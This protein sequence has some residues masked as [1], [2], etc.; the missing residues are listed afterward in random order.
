MKQ[1]W[2]ILLVIISLLLTESSQETFAKENSKNALDKNSDDCGPSGF[3]CLGNMIYGPCNEKSQKRVQFCRKGTICEDSGTDICI[4]KPPTCTT[5]GAFY[6][7]GYCNRYYLCVRT[8]SN[9]KQHIGACEP[10]FEFSL[11]T[12]NCTLPL[13]ADC[14][15]KKVVSVNLKKI[16]LRRVDEQGGYK[17]FVCPSAGLFA[18]PTSCRHYYMC[19]RNWFPILGGYLQSTRMICPPILPHFNKEKRLCWFYDD[20][21]G[22]EE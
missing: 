4:Q 22:D 9:L 17:I 5:E 18:D 1:F 2:K 14:S 13:E 11:S 19:V 21:C 3:R 7:P 8:G 15:V 20:N 12:G 6:L 16:P 10:G